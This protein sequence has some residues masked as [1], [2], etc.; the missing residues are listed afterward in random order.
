MNRLFLIF[1][2]L[3]IFTFFLGIFRGNVVRGFGNGCCMLKIIFKEKNFFSYLRK[4]YNLIGARKL[5]CW[6]NSRYFK[7]Y[8]V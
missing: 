4:D 5:K 3:G 8:L 1:E 2:F 7:N 6:N